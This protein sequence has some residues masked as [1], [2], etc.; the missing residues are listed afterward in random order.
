MNASR[1]RSQHRWKV[2]GSAVVVWL[3]ALFPIAGATMAQDATP[4][5]G[6]ASISSEPFGEA[7][8]QPVELYTLT[9]ANGM[10]VKIMTYGGILQ[11]IRVPDRDG[12]M[13]NVTLGYATLDGYLAAGNPS[14]FGCIAG[15][16]ANRIARGTFTLGDETYRLALN[17]GENTL[18]GGTKGFDKQVWAAEDVLS[19]DGV[20]VKLSRTSADGEEGY[21]G[22]LSADVTFTLTDDNELRID[23]HA[24]TDKTTI[25][26]LTNHSYW[27]L[28]GRG[29]G[30][31]QRP[32]AAAQR[33]PLHA[34]RRDLDPDR[35]DRPGGRDA[36]RFHHST[37]DWRARPRQLRAVR[38]SDAATT[39]TTS[40]IVPAPDDTTMM[41]AA[42][43]VEP[44]SG[45]TLEISTTEPGIQF[46][47]G[48]F[49]DG[50]ARTAR[51]ARS[52]ARATGSRWRPSTSPTRRISPTSRRPCWSPVRNTLRL[53]ST[54]SQWPVNGL[55]SR[56]RHVGSG[57]YNT[58]RLFLALIMAP[59]AAPVRCLA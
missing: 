52:T 36:V 34:D 35:R 49:L 23:Y 47:S 6:A 2:L 1:N 21:P 16:Y 37:R 22:T 54:R 41:L 56:S 13:E 15:R 46:Y 3:L 14:Y 7:D 9:N 18:H 45:R 19:G 8:G 33:Q 40:S 58:V 32:R 48:N 39:T 29:I 50:D 10:E 53:R 17:N 44:G 24:T 42:R 12:M 4:A 31:H 38:R 51:P 55:R 43:V 27:N 30:H 11:S 5:A 59:A 26:N 25:V 20:A 57:Q 28:A